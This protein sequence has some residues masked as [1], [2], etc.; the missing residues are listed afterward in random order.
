MRKR[1]AFAVLFSL[2]VATGMIR[3]L[4]AT[5]ADHETEPNDTAATANPLPHNV[6]MTGIISPSSDLDFFAQPGINATW[7]FIALLD[8]V[9]GTTPLA[10]QI[11]ALHN[12][13]ATALQS[14]TGSWERGS[15]IALQSYADGGI[16]H[17]LR[18]KAPAVTSYTLR[19]YNTIVATQPE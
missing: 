18:I 4:S 1:L 7:G 12:D 6:T 3:I 17:Y 8:T 11:T 13:G 5:P 9:S 10:A 16:T 14:D 19:Y 15:G 2:L